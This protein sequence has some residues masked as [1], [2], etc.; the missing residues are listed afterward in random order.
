[1]VQ[2]ERPGTLLVLVVLAGADSHH[3]AWCWPGSVMS[4][5]QSRIVLRRPATEDIGNMSSWK[6]I[7]KML[8]IEHFDEQEEKL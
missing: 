4:A 3:R 1:M 5:G 7:C 8:L 6:I 2:L